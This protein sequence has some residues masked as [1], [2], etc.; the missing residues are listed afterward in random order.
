MDIQANPVSRVYAEAL[1]RAA[2]GRG[3]VDDINDSLHGLADVMRTHPEFHHFLG[4]PMIDVPRKK[5]AVIKALQGNVDPLIVD[6]LCLLIDKDRT[7]ALAG[8]VQQFRVLADADAGRVRV[9]TTTAQP[10]SEGQSAA[11]LESLRQVLHSDCTLEATVDP[12]LIGGMVLRIGDKLYDGSV[13]RS[14]QRV[15]DTLMR[16]SGYEN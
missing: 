7:E 16:S 1:F 8:V 12:G 3:A 5:A 11:L 13:R 15:G 10:L 2:K 14:L 4:A 9:G 6:F